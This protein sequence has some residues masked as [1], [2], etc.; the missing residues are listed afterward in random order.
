MNRRGFLAIALATGAVGCVGR[1]GG[2]SR[3]SAPETFTPQSDRKTETRAKE[4]VIPGYPIPSLSVLY[5]GPMTADQM[6]VTVT[7]TNGDG[8]PVFERVGTLEPGES[9]SFDDIL[10]EAGSYRIEV[11]LDDGTTATKEIEV[12]DGGIG[13]FAGYQVS[14]SPSGIEITYAEV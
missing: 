11:R 5:S 6:R 12:A 10:E 2:G 9:V 7:I 13:Q 4:S 3:T 1:H 8:D 14:F